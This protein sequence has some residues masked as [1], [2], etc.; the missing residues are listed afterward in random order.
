MPKKSRDSRPSSSTS[1]DVA[2]DDRLRR[3]AVLAGACVAAG[4]AAYAMLLAAEPEPLSPVLRKIAREHNI[5]FGDFRR[6]YLATSTPVI[7]GGWST[8]PLLT[9]DDIVQSCGDDHL[10]DPCDPESIPVK[11]ARARLARVGWAG[12]R[13]ARRRV[14]RQFSRSARG[15]GQPVVPHVGWRRPR[16]LGRAAL[17]L[18]RVARHLLPAPARKAAR[19]AL[20]SRRLPAADGPAILDA[21]RRPAVASV[22]LRRPGSLA[23][24]LPPRFLWH[25]V[26]DGGAR[27]RE[28]LPAD[29]PGHDAAPQAG[30]ARRRATRRSSASGRRSSARS[31]SG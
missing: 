11:Y 2:A 30:A 3:V 9:R 5:S 12:G 31:R 22:A 24:R 15:A 6:K 19:A 29:R 28:G 13:A 27:G 26:L 17:P 4:A 1:A 25:A 21:V 23:E 10:H 16:A 18:R 20:L 8:E 7:V 14:A